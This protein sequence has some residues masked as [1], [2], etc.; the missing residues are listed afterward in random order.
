MTTKQ[1][2][3]NKAISTG[4]LIYVDEAVVRPISLD[5]DILSYMDMGDL[6]EYVVDI[7][8]VNEVTEHE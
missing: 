4:D 7:N 5:G 2:I 6:L 8:K 1:T 3:I